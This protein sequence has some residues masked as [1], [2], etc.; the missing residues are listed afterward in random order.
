MFDNYSNYYDL[1]Y[2]DKNYQEETNYISS[3]LKKYEINDGD[4]LE[5]GSGTGKHGCLLAEKG[6]NVH[7]IELSTEMVSKAKTHPKFNCQQG[8]IANVKMSQSFDAVLSLFHVMS[9]Q[10][11]NNQIKAVFENASK[12]LNSGGLFIFDIWYSPAVHNLQPS[13]RVKRFEND[14]FKII[15]V[16]EPKNFPN[17]NLVDVNYTFFIN[18]LRNNSLSSF[19]ETHTMRHFSLPEIDVLAENYGFK[20]VEAQEFLSKKNP[21][22]ILGV[23]V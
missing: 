23:Y 13:V 16:A 22:E 17:K 20:L 4:L 5:F 8:D 18:E 1:L 7:G 12:H 21:S 9:Y 6:Y 11:S 2:Q 19:K 14:K 15:R 10:I 3:L